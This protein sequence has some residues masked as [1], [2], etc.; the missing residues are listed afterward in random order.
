VAVNYA[1]HG[2]ELCRRSEEEIVMKF[3][4]HLTRAVRHEPRQADA[5]RLLLALHRQHGETVRSVFGQQIVAHAGRFVEGTL[6][7]T[8]LL[9]LVAAAPASSAGRRTSTRTPAATAGAR[10]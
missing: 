7:D 3:N 5:A 10:S 4:Q 1:R 8:S 2:M 6:D 9:G